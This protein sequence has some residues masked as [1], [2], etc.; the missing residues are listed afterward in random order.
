VAHLSR[1][2]RRWRL[3]RIPGDAF[4]PFVVEIEE[5]RH[6]ECLIE[7]TPA[8]VASPERLR[9]SSRARSAPVGALGFMVAAAVRRA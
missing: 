4:R 3:D 8:P 7:D 9:C 5:P 1:R 6:R 2:R